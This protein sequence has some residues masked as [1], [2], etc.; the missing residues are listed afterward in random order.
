MGAMWRTDRDA[1]SPT[2]ARALLAALA[3]SALALVLFASFASEVK[4][5][6]ATFDWN[7]D[8]GKLSQW[9]QDLFSVQSASAAAIPSQQQC[10]ISPEL[11]QE[12]GAHNFRLSQVHVGSGFRMQKVL[13]KAQRGEKVRIGVI[14]GSVSLGHGTD[15]VTGQRNKYGAVKPEDQWH[16]FV[17]KY[18]A[19]LSGVE[20]E[21]IMGAKA[22]TDSSFFEWCWA[23]L[24]GTELDL[25]LVELAVNDDYRDGFDSAENLLRSL[26]QLETQ[27]AVLYADTFALGWTSTRSSIIGAQDYQSSLASWYDVPQIGTRGALLTAMI[28]DPSLREPLFLSDVRHG[29]VKVHRFLGSM[30]VG[31]MQQ[32]LC[33]IDP[34][35][36]DGPEEE[37]EEADI[38]LT[39]EEQARRWRRKRGLE[40]EFAW[41]TAEGLGEVPRVKMNEAWNADVSHPVKAPVCEVAGGALKPVNDSK[42]WTLFN[43][44]YSKY[45]YETKKANSE[46]IVFEA[47]VKEGATGQVAVS[48]LRSK[49]Y[50]L[51]KARCSVG[52]QTAVLDGF[53]TQSAS[54]AQTMVVAKNLPP[55]KHTVSCRTLP[56]NAG[57]QA[58]AFRLMGVMTV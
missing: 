27:P 22:A 47:E 41:P 24:I 2:T 13:A 34:L 1:S 38:D 15:P 58:T 8:T 6:L 20:P 52:K 5:P 36:L 56:A 39:E 30:I 18:L 49:Q 14:G 12:F 44:K 54:V 55:G 26:L 4:N 16:Q 7:L 37:I 42:D 29:S 53:W 57:E 43:W 21:F 45:Y 51:G 23:T 32:E 17:R 31:Y 46:E 40:G 35:V 9:R 19:D 48:Y 28:R 10:G 50:N 33:R 25:V 3:L 11:V